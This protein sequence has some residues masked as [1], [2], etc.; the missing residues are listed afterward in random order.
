M[1]VWIEWVEP[2]DKKANPVYMRVSKE[3]AI[4]AQ[5]EIAKKLNKPYSSDEEA[6]EDFMVVHWAKIIECK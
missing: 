2:F 3:T 4:A 6:L 5:K 1:E